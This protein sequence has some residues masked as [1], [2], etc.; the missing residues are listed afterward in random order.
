MWWRLKRSE[1]AKRKGAGNRRALKKIVES[2]EVPGILAYAGGEP[3]AWCSI[4]PRERFPLL[5]RS[6]T[7]KRVDEQPVWS[8]VCF[9]VA[10]PFRGKGITVPV[11][12]A[13]VKYAREHGAEVIE[14]YPMEPKRGRMPDVFAWTGFAPTFRRADFVEV[15]RRSESRPI[16]RYSVSRDSDDRPKSSRPRSVRRTSTGSGSANPTQR[17]LM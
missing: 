2:G 4:A 14:G 7:L 9:F 10:R 8:V 6:R 13:A 16:M 17:T 5:E 15:L 3:V 11:L 1:F 12:R